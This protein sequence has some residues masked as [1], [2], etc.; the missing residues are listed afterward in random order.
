MLE[1]KRSTVSVAEGIRQN[2]GIV[3]DIH[4]GILRDLSTKKTYAIEKYP[5]FMERVIKAGGLM[6]SL[7]KR[8]R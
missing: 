1:L 3:V 7:K 8:K 4:R 2:D 5:P 6:E